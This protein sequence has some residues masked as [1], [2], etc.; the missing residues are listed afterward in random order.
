MST[1]RGAV[2]PMLVLISFSIASGERFFLLPNGDRYLADKVIVTNNYDSPAYIIGHSVDG[3]ACT[4][5]ESIDQ[6]C[7]EIGVTAV[8]PFYPGRL[9]K[10][11]LRREVS[12]IYLFTLRDNVDARSALE[13]LREDPNIDLA[14]LYIVP[15]FCYTPNDPRFDEQWFLTHI[16]A[17]DCWNMV[18]GDTTRKAIIGIVDSG[19]YWDHPDLAGNIWINYPEDLNHNG[20]LDSGDINHVDDDGN[21]YADDV[22]GW[23]FGNRDN[24]PIEDMPYHGTIVAGCASEVTDNGTGAA[25][26]GFSARLLCAKITNSQGVVV[27]AYQGFVYAADNGADVIN[28]SFASRSHSQTEQNI[29]NAAYQDGSYIVAA[30]GNDNGQDTTYPAGYEHVLAVTGVD[31]ND[32]LIPGFGYGNWVDVCAPGSNMLSTWGPEG[33]VTGEGTSISSPVASGLAAL[34]RAWLPSYNPDQVDSLIK[35][36]ADS[37]GGQNPNW[38]QAILINAASWL[39]F[40]GIDELPIPDEI[41]LDQNYPN[42]FNTRTIIKYKLASAAEVS[43]DIYDIL[44][45]KIDTLAS[46]LHSAGEHTVIWDAGDLASGVYFYRLKAGEELRTNRMLLLK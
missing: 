27:G 36:S 3:L 22:L 25:G 23:D 4:G 37:I 12:R 20:V 11:A 24:N 26:I 21:G 2:L 32:Q 40:V 42:P 1:V 14:E 13:Q 28:C 10:P 8:E 33:Y 15:E 19:V 31:E 45:R 5:V 34:I 6:L 16:H 9:A 46:G 38:P 30:A 39:H 7:R 43:I 17:D 41:T 44:G 35:I 18:R 29:I